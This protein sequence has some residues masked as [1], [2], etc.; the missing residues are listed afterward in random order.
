MPSGMF[1]NVVSYKVCPESGLL[2][3]ENCKN[4]YIE[5]YLLG[6][7]PSYCNVHN[8]SENS[9][10]IDKSES[11]KK[12]VNQIIEGNANEID[13]ID[14]QELEKKTMNEESNKVETTIDTKNET[15]EKDA[16][17]KEQSK[18]IIEKNDENKNNNIIENIH[19]D[20]STTNNSTNTEQTS[21]DTSFNN[22]TEQT[23]E[24]Q[25]VVTN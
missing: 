25:N 20:N 24:L 22:S 19:Q 6:T 18:N 9:G 4:A 7:I 3:R 5:Y 21:G 11:T 23:Q 17:S 13:A 8:G 15:T 16:P 14:P 1:D 2:A 10:A 12:A